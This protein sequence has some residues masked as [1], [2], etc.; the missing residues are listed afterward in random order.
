MFLSPKIFVILIIW[1]YMWY[2]YLKCQVT[3]FNLLDG[4]LEYLV[5]TWVSGSLMFVN[6][7]AIDVINSRDWI[8]VCPSIYGSDKSSFLSYCFCCKILIKRG[9]RLCSERYIGLP[10]LYDTILTYVLITQNTTKSHVYFHL[11]CLSFYARHAVMC[12][13]NLASFLITT[14]LRSRIRV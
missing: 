4:W 11:R 1:N 13:T 8:T 2:S 10:E 5:H 3:M 6:G 12:F 14:F 9:S 7:V